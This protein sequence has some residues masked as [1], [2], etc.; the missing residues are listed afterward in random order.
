MTRALL[1]TWA[2]R[3][4][5]DGLIIVIAQYLIVLLAVTFLL[6]AMMFHPH[7]PYYTWQ[8][9]HVINIGDQKMPVAAYWHPGTNATAT[10]LFSHG[11]AE[12]IGDL[13]ELFDALAQSGVSVLAYDYP[14]YGLSAGSPTEKGCYEAAEKAYAFLI[15]YQKLTP[16]CI[17]IQGRSLGSGPAC[18]LA[19]KYPV[20]GLILE[21]GFL[22]AP[23]VVTRVRLLPQDPFPNINRIEHIPCPKLF[24]HGTHDS[25]IPFWHGKEMYERSSG[26]KDYHW[27]SEAGHN[28]LIL[29]FGFKRY[30]QVIK[31][32]ADK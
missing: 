17:I 32:F 5:L 1:Q 25:V 31:A 21:S 12:D 23:R 13:S 16:A 29:T 14:G 3:I 7:E 11:N 19:E 20:K 8:T 24:L 22:S 2:K 6:N 4:V 27:V 18:Y 30:T 15:E 26:P 10:V 28:D 9:P